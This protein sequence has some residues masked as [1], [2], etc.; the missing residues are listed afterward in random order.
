MQRED[1]TNR[2][3]E[4]LLGKYEVRIMKDAVGKE[5]VIACRALFVS[6]E[7]K[8][9]FFCISALTLVLSFFSSWV[10]VASS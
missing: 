6:R 1:L 3:S 4:P 5:I 10:V 7:M 9:R 8:A 2:W